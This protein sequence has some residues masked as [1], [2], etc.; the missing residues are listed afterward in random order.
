[1][2]DFLGLG[3]DYP[4]N[5]IENVL[6]Q[7][8]LVAQHANVEGE[9]VHTF[10]NHMPA[11][12]WRQKG[13]VTNTNATTSLLHHAA[14]LRQCQRCYHQ[15]QHISGDDNRMTDDAS[16]KW[17]LSDQNFLTYFNSTYPQ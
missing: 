4:C 5:P 16:Q 13:S 15:H 8:V 14:F 1:V 2:D 6:H 11:A 7:D 3:Q 9:M 10:C 12:Y 17:N